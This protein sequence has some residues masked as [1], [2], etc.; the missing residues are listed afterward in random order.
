M[1]QLYYKEINSGLSIFEIKPI[2]DKL[3]EPAKKNVLQYTLY[4]P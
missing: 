1:A 4:K 2:R 3:K